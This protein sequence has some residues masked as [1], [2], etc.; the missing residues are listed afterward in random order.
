MFSLLQ[1]NSNKYIK[2]I[3][4]HKNNTMEEAKWAA[5]NGDLE[6]LKKSASAPGFDVNADVGMGRSLIHCAADY[7]Q[8]EVLEFLIASG[9][10]VNAPDKHGITPLLNAIFEGHTNAVKLLLAKGADK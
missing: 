8:C 6:N 4:Q 1:K 10:N 2:T 9:A 7:G 3:K 5:Q